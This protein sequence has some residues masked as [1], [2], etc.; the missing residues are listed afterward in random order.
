MKEDSKSE[1][2]NN[3]SRTCS[4]IATYVFAQASEDGRD[5]QNFNNHSM[6]VHL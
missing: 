4:G 5:K 3:E 2:M 1:K 6:N